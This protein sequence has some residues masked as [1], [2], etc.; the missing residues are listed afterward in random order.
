M[1]KWFSAFARLAFWQWVSHSCCVALEL[2]VAPCHLT[3]L[4]SPSHT[5]TCCT[6]TPFCFPTPFFSHTQHQKRSHFIRGKLFL[7]PVDGIESDW[8][9]FLLVAS[10]KSM[11]RQRFLLPLLSIATASWPSSSYKFV[12]RLDS[13]L[14]FYLLLSTTTVLCFLAFLLSQICTETPILTSISLLPFTATVHCTET[15]IFLP[16]SSTAT[17][18]FLF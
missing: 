5:H 7:A 9:W 13:H 4:C 17:C 18:E 16:L 10:P 3:C 6:S 14:L 12:P 1:Y 8:N 15:T 11:P 2:L